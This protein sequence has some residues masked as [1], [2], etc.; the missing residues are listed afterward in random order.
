MWVR[1]RPRVHRF[2]AAAAASFEVVVF[3]ASH[4][5]YAMKVLDN[6][7]PT[8]N[9]IKHRL[10]RDSCTYVE[11]NYVKDL[12]VTRRDLRRT[13]IVDNNPAAY[14]YQVDN[15]IPIV[16]WYDDADDTEL[17]KLLE[18]LMQLRHEADFRKVIRRTYKSY[19]LV[20]AAP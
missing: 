2:L 3:T 12:S 16:S 8:G 18:F 4:H 1:E 19:K 7:D 9:L 20:S 10:Y 15:G 17:D 11:G 13:C 14:G 6:L 5:E